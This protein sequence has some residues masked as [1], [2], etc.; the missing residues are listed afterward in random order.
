MMARNTLTGWWMLDSN[1]C[2]YVSKVVSTWWIKTMTTE[3]TKKSDSYHNDDQITILRKM[4][5]ISTRRMRKGFDTC[6]STWRSSLP[7]V[8]FRSK[9]AW[10]IFDRSLLITP[11]CCCSR[12]L[13]NSWAKYQLIL[14]A[15]W[16]LLTY[17]IIHPPMQHR[18]T[19]RQDFNRCAENKSR[20]FSAKVQASYTLT[21]SLP[22]SWDFCR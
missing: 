8:E 5:P 17:I 19:L 16:E 18:M 3:I 6:V 2:W 1:R 15:L 10:L 4:S 21:I 11:H 9:T 12:R 22:N 14:S 13:N 20:N 7:R